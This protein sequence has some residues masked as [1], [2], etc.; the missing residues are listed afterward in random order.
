M[1]WR[2]QTQD[3]PAC[4]WAWQM[5]P[6]FCLKNISNSLRMIQNGTIETG[7]FFLPDMVQ[8]CST[9][10]CTSQGTKTFQWMKSKIS[11]SWVPKLQ[12]IQRIFSLRRL[13]QLQVHLVRAFPMQSALRWQKKCFAPGS[14][15]NSW[16]I[17]PMSSRETA[18]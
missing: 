2:L 11:A 5:W 9:V 13:R 3:I 6:P 10:S 15:R 16:I 14:A 12:D 1:R 17:I 18:V 8:C 4:R 7:S